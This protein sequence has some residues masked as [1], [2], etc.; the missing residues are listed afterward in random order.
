MSP[1]SSQTMSFRF[2]AIDIERC[3]GCEACVIICP[4]VFA[5]HTNGKAFVFN[6]HKCYTCNCQEAIDNCLVKAIYWE[7]LV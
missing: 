4:E 5:L 6:P 3:V 7:Y 1:G 2:P